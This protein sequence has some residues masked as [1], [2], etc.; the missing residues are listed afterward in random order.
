MGVWVKMAKDKPV[1]GKIVIDQGKGLVFEREEDVYVHFAK[2]IRQLEKELLAV[3]TEDDIPRENFQEYES[4]L[5]DVLEDPDEIWEDRKTFESM[6][7]NVF[8]ADFETED[9]RFTYVAVAYVGDGGNSFVF[10]H[11]PT[12]DASVVDEFRRGRK[13]YE[14]TESTER[15]G[16]LGEDALSTGDE[17]AVSLYDAML[18]LRSETDIEEKEFS[19]FSQ[20]RESTIEESDEIWRK[21]DSQGNILVNFIKEFSIESGDIFF[22]VVALEEPFSESHYVLFSFPT[23]DP[24]LVERYRQG[25]NLETEEFTREESH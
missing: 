10:I 25:D 3:R 8:I 20:L 4:C 23:N 15:S 19:E 1:K 7:L 2:E 21:T 13:I 11:F 5:T 24:N 12:L 16:D 14:K 18:K 6:V 22:I 9:E 17:L